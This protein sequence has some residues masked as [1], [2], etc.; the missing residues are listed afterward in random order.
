MISLEDFLVGGLLPAAV[1]A[2]AL[3]VAWKVSGNSTISWMTSFLSGYTAGQWGLDARGIGLGEAISKFYAPEVASD[4]VPMLL[5]FA[6]VPEVVSQFGKRGKRASWL[7]FTGVASFL[8][9]RMLSL[10]KDYPTS[11]LV[12]AGFNESPWT[13]TDVALMIV[14]ATLVMLHLWGLAKAGE[15]Q[16]APVMRSVL[17]MLVAV[18]GAAVLALSGSL[19]TGQLMGVVAASLGGSGL[20][21]WILRIEAGPEAA[22]ALPQVAIVGLLLVAALFIEE[23]IT[24]SKAV[25][26]IASLLMAMS[27]LPNRKKWQLGLRPIACLVPLAMVVAMAGMEFATSQIPAE[28][29][30]PTEEVNPYSNWQ[31]E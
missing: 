10:H 16:S 15:R 20:T 7:P 4:W 18:G 3:V 17:T 1:A 23:G 8:T 30:V 9:W 5:V 24:F 27:V 29:E 22:P 2:A 31:P 25:L 12:V 14:G 13:W 21:A 19:T 6:A 11:E 28:S 26:L